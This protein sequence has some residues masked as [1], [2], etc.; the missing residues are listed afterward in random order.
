MIVKVQRTG[1]WTGWKWNSGSATV[2]WLCSSDFA[3]NVRLMRIPTEQQ[4]EFMEK[5]KRLVF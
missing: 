5:P 1:K 2:R 3:G 4:V